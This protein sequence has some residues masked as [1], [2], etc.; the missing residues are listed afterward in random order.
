MSKIKM[1]TRTPSID[2]TPM[3]D[4]F[5]LLLTFFMLTTSFRPQ[6]AKPV[7]TPNSISETTSPSMNL[8]TV[9]ISKDSKVY[10]N[11][12][13][14]SDSSSHV[15]AKV[16]KGVGEYYKINF[17]SEELN[18]FEK[19]NSFGMP[20][21]DISAWL[22]EQDPKVKDLM[23]TGIPTDS[24]DNQLNVWISFARN[25]NSVAEVA[26]KGDFKS[27]FKVVK[28]VMDMFQL[29]GINK[30]NLTTNLEKVEVKKEELN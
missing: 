22:S 19:L 14:G 11:M 23:Q 18:K 6:E 3:V 29:N 24:I 4:L 9:L 17:T 10:F 16:L 13:N 25:T 1:R 12:D 30:F 26:I 27:D 8:I 15:R 28:K 21:K 20:V 5:F 7:D 2:M